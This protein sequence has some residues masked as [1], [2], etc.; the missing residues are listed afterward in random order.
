M[1]HLSGRLIFT[2]TARN[3]WHHIE[4]Q[5][6]NIVIIDLSARYTYEFGMEKR[7]FGLDSTVGVFGTR[8][9]NRSLSD[10]SI[11]PVLK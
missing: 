2:V 9:L 8:T 11:D 5:F 7:S 6:D 4:Y 10:I 1:T 3:S